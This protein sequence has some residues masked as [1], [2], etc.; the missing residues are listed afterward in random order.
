MITRTRQTHHLFDHAQLFMLCII[1]SCYQAVQQSG[2][3]VL[4][5][6]LTDS[7]HRELSQVVVDCT[8]SQQQV[9]RTLLSWCSK[10]RVGFH[11]CQIL[12][13]SVEKKCLSDSVVVFYGVEEIQVRLHFLTGST[14]DEQLGNSV[15][16]SID[17]GNQVPVVPVP[18]FQKFLIHT[19][20]VGVEKTGGNKI[21]QSR[22]MDN[23]GRMWSKSTHTGLRGVAPSKIEERD[24]W[25]AQVDFLLTNYI[26]LVET[27]L[28][29]FLKANNVVTELILGHT[30]FHYEKARALASVFADPRVETVCEI[31][32]NAG[33][34]MLNALLARE[35]IQI[36]SFDLGEYWDVY[37]KYSYQLLQKSFPEQVTV[38]LGDSTSTVPKFIRE[39]PDQKC[40]VIF[41]D[42]G[43][44]KEV[45]AADI[46]NMAPMA[47]RTFHRLIVDDADWGDV[48]VAWDEAVSHG[49]VQETGWVHSNY[50]REYD[51]DYI[52][53]KSLGLEVPVL[54]PAKNSGPLNP[55]VLKSTGAMSFGSY[56]Y[57]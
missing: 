40:N 52:V 14:R 8:A 56:M 29:S 2:A 43:H 36:I 15:K 42:G 9:K 45:A 49:Y 33:H 3:E 31:G 41:I 39:R 51:L 10:H 23:V 55:E 25:D 38:V 57:I 19:E 34:S 28:H 32:F 4:R 7:Q 54:K 22:S 26:T 24:P 11:Q 20:I 18:T 27:F 1:M 16:K 46:F 37:S 30:G 48:R 21:A 6:T 44:T 47:N 5:S 53:D 50:C 17:V 35:G 13:T 12:T